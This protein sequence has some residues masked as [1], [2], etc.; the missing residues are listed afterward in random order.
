MY[1]LKSASMF[2]AKSQRACQDW[3]SGEKSNAGVSPD[4]VSSFFEHCQ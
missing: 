4:T 3:E 1:Y 2:V